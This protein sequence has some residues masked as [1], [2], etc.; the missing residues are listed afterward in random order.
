MSL[1]N[2]YPAKKKDMINSDNT[3]AGLLNELPYY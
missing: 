3:L 2:R 1:L